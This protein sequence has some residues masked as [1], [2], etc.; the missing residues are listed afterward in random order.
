MAEQAEEAVDP[1]AVELALSRRRL[2]RR[3]NW[4]GAPTLVPLLLLAPVFSAPALLIL[5]P[6][7]TDIGVAVDLLGGSTHRALLELSAVS[8]AFFAIWG[9]GTLLLSTLSDYVGRKPVLLGCAL[10]TCVLSFAC[11]VAPSFSVYAVC[12]TL[13]GVTCGAQGAVAFLH[14]LEWGLPK[15]NGFLTCVLMSAWSIFGIILAGVSFAP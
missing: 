14:T 9:P 15:D 5:Q 2:G 7:F 12:R 1:A 4:P 8:S 13:L 3:G 11:S 10:G 6:V